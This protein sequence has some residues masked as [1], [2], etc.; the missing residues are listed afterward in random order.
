MVSVA[1]LVFKAQLVPLVL[2]A[3]PVNLALLELLVLE[4]LARMDFLELQA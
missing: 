3:H 1:H 4:H 2:L